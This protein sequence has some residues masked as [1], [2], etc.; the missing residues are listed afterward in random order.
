MCEELKYQFEYDM[1]SEGLDCTLHEDGQ[2]YLKAKTRIAYK[3][4][5]SGYRMGLR[6]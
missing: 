2:Q 6:G 5:C 4:F 1:L 3:A